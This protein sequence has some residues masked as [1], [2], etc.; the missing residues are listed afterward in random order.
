[1]LTGLSAFPL[2]PFQNEGI[3][4]HAFV[5]L[6]H[7]LAEAEVDSI[8]VLGS[9]GSYMYLNR[10]ERRRV[11]QLAFEHAGNIPIIAGIGALRTRDVLQAAEDAQTAGASGV[12]LAPVSYQPLTEDEVF[13]LYKQVSGE[14]SI[15]LCVY[16]NPSTTKFTFTDELHGRISSLPNV[17]SIKIPGLPG[18][19]AEAQ[20][21]VQKLR[22]LIPEDVTIG[23]SGDRFAALGLNAGCDGW[24]SVLGGLFPRTAMHI[25]RSAQEGRSQEASRLSEELEPIW[26]LFDR[27]GSLRPTA[28]IALRRGWISGEGLP[29]PLKPLSP[30]ELGDAAALID[31]LD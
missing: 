3:D 1:M 13:D 9:T 11:I 6:V 31:R 8:G 20:D 28:T 12:L 30:A 4:E 25:V 16:D 2:T 17:S 19:A 5:R 21:R 22:A 27:F 26:T 14:L 24:Y 18:N 23:I 7:N 29:R 15:P 10:A